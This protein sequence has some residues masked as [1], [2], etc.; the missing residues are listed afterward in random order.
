MKQEVVDHEYKAEHTQYIH[1]NISTSLHTTT[2]LQIAEIYKP[3]PNT[4]YAY[5]HDNDDH[6]H[7]PEKTFDT[8]IY[9]VNDYEEKMLQRHDEN[10]YRAK[11]QAIRKE[12][13][14]AEIHMQKNEDFVVLYTIEETNEK[15]QK[16]VAV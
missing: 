15:Q 4:K 16:Y 11:M 5:S 13:Q 7:K 10:I 9:K 6:V 1:K 14:N 2:Q 3:S 12:I 8:I